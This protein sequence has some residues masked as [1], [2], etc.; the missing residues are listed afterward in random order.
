MSQ[1]ERN[2]VFVA[3]I[4]MLLTHILQRYIHRVV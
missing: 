1:N 2:A 3:G 4:D